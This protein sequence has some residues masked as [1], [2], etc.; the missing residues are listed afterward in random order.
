MGYTWG[1]GSRLGA[2]KRATLTQAPFTPQWPACLDRKRSIIE[3]VSEHEVLLSYP[4]SPWTL[5]CSFCARPR[6]I[7]PSFP[8]RSRCTA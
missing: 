1:L 8:S 3:Q 2:E 7:R 5:S 6:W 4:T